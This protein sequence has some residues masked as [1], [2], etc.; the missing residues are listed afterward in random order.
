MIRNIYEKICLL[1]WKS[2]VQFEKGWYHN[3]ITEV[4]RHQNVDRQFKYCPICLFN[5][6][7]HVEYAFH[8]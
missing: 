6:N 7:F 1:N 2:L 4:G 5:S 3:L 8:M